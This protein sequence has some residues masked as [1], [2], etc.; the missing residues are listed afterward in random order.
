MNELEKKIWSLEEEVA[1]IEEEKAES[2]EE[3]SKLQ[4]F[5]NVYLLEF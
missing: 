2:E 5:L 1:R 4:V 3:R